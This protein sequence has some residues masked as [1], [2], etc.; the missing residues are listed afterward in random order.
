MANAKDLEPL[1]SNFKIFVAGDP[2]TGK[3]RF[4]S[5]FPGPTFLFDFDKGALS[6]RGKDVEYEQYDRSPQ[7]WVKFEKDCARIVKAARAGEYKTIIVDS[8]TALAELAMERALSL[9]PKRSATGG[10]LWNVHYGMV[11]NLVE[12]KLRQLI[13]VPC[14][15]LMIGHLKFEY[16]S[17]TGAVIKIT[18][19]LPGDLSI[20]FPGNFDEYYIATTKMVNQKTQYVLQTATRGLLCARSRISGEEKLL[21]DFMPNDFQ[22]LIANIEKGAS[23]MKK[24]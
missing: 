10:P 17:E 19:M 21:P 6:Y 14:H 24:T 12:G 15:V 18:P 8:T 2:G 9:D 20:R 3:S 4:G 11:K 22:E 13:D 1:E 5:T 7:G 23:P 16:D